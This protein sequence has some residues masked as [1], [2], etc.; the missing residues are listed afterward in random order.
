MFKR[1]SFKPNADESVKC[2]NSF[3]N[4]VGPCTPISYYKSYKEDSLYSSKLSE[5]S[6]QKSSSSSIGTIIFAGNLYVKGLH[7]P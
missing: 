7:I 4:Q 1:G 6:S 2:F 5:K 3:K